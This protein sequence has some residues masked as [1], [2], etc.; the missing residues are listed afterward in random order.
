MIDK[1]AQMVYNHGKEDDHHEKM[2]SKINGGSHS[3]SLLIRRGNDWSC[4]EFS[5]TTTTDGRS[6]E[7]NLYWGIRWVAVGI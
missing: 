3:S 4:S 1:K 2:V 7:Q 5:A 6:R